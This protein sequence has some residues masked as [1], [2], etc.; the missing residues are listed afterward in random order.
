[1]RL[2]PGLSLSAFLLVTALAAC[3]G[4]GGSAIPAGQTTAAPVSPPT[5]TANTPTPTP[6][7]AVTSSAGALPVS[8][9]A[10][11]PQALPTVAGITGTIALPGASAPAGTI[12]NTTTFLTPSGSVP[13]LQSV[14]R[15]VQAL[16]SQA[17][18]NVTTYL[19]VNVTPS[20]SIAMPNYPNFTFSIP[21]SVVAPGTTLYV[22]FYDGSTWHVPAF[23]PS[24]TGTFNGSSTPAAVTTL[25]AGTTYVFAVYSPNPATPTPSPSPSVAPVLVN[26]NPTNSLTLTTQGATAIVTVS[27]AGSTPFVTFLTASSNCNTSSAAILA[28]GPPSVSTTTGSANFS[29][30]ATANGSCTIFFSSS[31]GGT[32]ATVTVTVAIPGASAAPSASASPTA[33]PLA[34]S[35]SL[36]GPTSGPVPTG[37]PVGGWGPTAVANAFNFPVQ[38]GYNGSGITVAIVISSSVSQSD[39]QAYLSYFQTPQ[40]SRTITFEPIDNASLA[41][42]GGEDQFEATLDLETIAGLAPGA[43]IIVYVMPQLTTQEENHAYNQI[44]LDGSAS[45]VSSSFGGCEANGLLNT[46]QIL[47]ESTLISQGAQKGITYVAASGDSGSACNYS[48]FL[49]PGFYIQGVSYPASDPNVTAVGGTETWRPSGY[50]LTSGQAWND[51]NFGTVPQGATGGGISTLFSIPSQ[52]AGLAGVSSVIARNVPDI[53]MPAEYDALYLNSSWS[54]ALGTSWAAPQFAA[55]MAEVYQYCNT[56]TLTSP[57]SAPYTVFNRAGYN[58]FNAVTSGQNAFSLTTGLTYPYAAVRGYNNA[59]GLGVPLGMQFA[60]TLCPNRVQSSHATSSVSRTVPATHGP[61]QSIRSDATPSVR[62]LTDQGRRSSVEQ[63]RIQ[64]VMRPTPTLASDEETV[65]GLLQSA[66]FTIVHT[67][68]NHM[69]IDADAG[70]STVEQFFNTELHDVT[71]GRYGVRYMPVTQITI[72]ASIAPYV[73]GLSLDNVVNMV[74][75]HQ[76]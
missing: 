61:P 48:T 69:I 1:M 2:V 75:P 13:V 35:V 64:I 5:L 67:F 42:A 71:E 9:A 43:N 59:T 40:T 31:L 15:A 74:S 34:A 47:G 66:G 21:S 6:A 51:L 49:G 52:Q 76:R 29:I 55:M 33:S 12:M 22:A 4:G 53:A 27:Q 30:T 20:Q 68:S 56:K 11:S 23:G 28:Y 19:Y 58:A 32:A 63:T 39:Y 26:G 57:A 65:I 14:G 3:G 44:L 41:P 54:I 45:V 62:G 8:A 7:P 38:S 46:L 36:T 10:S 37:F 24:T 60:Q 73:A 16:R 50:S 18:F 17:G 72:P 25:V 70:S